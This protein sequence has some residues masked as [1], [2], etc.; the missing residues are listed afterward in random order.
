M[1]P[2]ALIGQIVDERY[3]IISIAGRGGM[4]TVYRAKQIDLARPVA[5]KL[6][7][8]RLGS[9]DDSLIRFKREARAISKLNNVHIASFYSYGLAENGSPYMAMEFLEAKSLEDLI[10]GEKQLNWERA[11]KISMQILAALEHAHSMG[12]IHRDLK[13][14]N[15]MLQ[16]NPEEDFV[17][18]VDFGLAKL[19]L[20]DETISQRLT[21]TGMLVGTPLYM[22]PE[23]CS[24]QA[25]DPRT[26]IY[27]LGV[28]IYEMLCGQT[29][30]VSENP[31]LVIH[32]QIQSEPVPP[33]KL[34]SSKLPTGL[35]LVILKCLEKSPFD[36]YKNVEALKAD[37]EKIVE[38]QGETIEI[39]LK[40]QPKTDKRKRV[41]V[42]ALTIIGITVAIACFCYFGEPGTILRAKQSLKSDHSNS[43]V[44]SWLKKADAIAK[45]N[46][47][48]ALANE[49][50]QLARNALQIDSKPME[51][52]GHADLEM[53]QKMLE[54]GSDR[55]AA[56][57]ALQGVSDIGPLLNRKKKQWKHYAR[58]YDDL[59][60]LLLDSKQAISNEKLRSLSITTMEISRAL[61]D[62]DAPSQYKI[63]ESA[64]IKHLIP[65]TQTLAETLCQRDDVLVY[66]N[67]KTELN[68]ALPVTLDLLAQIY[69]KNSV[70]ILEHLLDLADTAKLRAFPD[71]ALALL[72][73][74]SK[75]IELETKN[76]KEDASIDFSVP[77]ARLAYLYA[78]LAD[79][80]I[81]LN[82]IAQSEKCDASKPLADKI[83]AESLRTFALAMMNKEDEALP[84]AKALMKQIYTD[85]DNSESAFI[86]R[87]RTVSLISSIF[88]R[89]KQYEEE[90][91]LLKKEVNFS[92]SLLP[93]HKDEY[94]KLV[95]AL[96]Q[97]Q[98]LSGK[99]P[100]ALSSL[101][102]LEETVN[103]YNETLD[104]DAGAML[105]Y[106][107]VK[108]HQKKRLIAA[109]NNLI[110][111]RKPQPAD[112]LK[113]YWWAFADSL[114]AL[115]GDENN[116]A[117]SNLIGF[118]TTGFNQRLELK[119][120]APIFLVHVI[121][122]LNAIGE[123]KLANRLERRALKRL[124]EKNR[125]IFNNHIMDQD[126]QDESP[127]NLQITRLQMP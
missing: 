69:G 8:E 36:R 27:S 61:Q 13:P 107:L 91:Q 108:E 20:G 73:Q 50:F 109:L 71:E 63:L 90:I 88:H 118:I 6:L 22:S 94:S 110:Q 100:E 24:G 121:H 103:R 48:T 34:I 10:T 87:F 55:M 9:E 19:A 4:G 96:A 119:N 60:K 70:R 98:L 113:T 84:R 17:K 53:G 28:I 47:K 35:E 46:S 26:D 116:F 37:L 45:D 57:F 74:A 44:I 86:S 64:Y 89:R 97:V 41:F 111:H 16:N 25:V 81:T 105:V 120:P 115:K 3:E 78:G 82:C 11:I 56:M 66:T 72:E 126:S 31:M 85:D 102:D 7:D 124:D 77:W 40:S 23:Q 127:F 29:P 2:K 39:K 95:Q 15:I 83:E 30:F 32:K 80:K 18:V 67:D 104:T 76:K 101:N 93:M 21:K 114:D 12:I 62:C 43:N 106:C 51:E 65:P 33:S 14:A 117:Y 5:L 122:K 38:N 125:Q 123:I 54:S 75:Q 49:I 42:A 112:K 59:G 68:T 92:K 79:N 99:S 52:A 1:D 58:L